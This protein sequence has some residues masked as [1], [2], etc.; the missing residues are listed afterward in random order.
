M[1]TR[2]A[3]GEKRNRKRMAMVATVYSIA[4]HCRCPE[5]IM[6]L[7]EEAQDIPSSR[8]RARNKR[9][10]A[11]VERDPGK[12]TEELFEETHRRDPEH[13]RLWVMLVDGHK[14]QL[15]HIWANI[16]HPAMVRSESTRHCA[17]TLLNFFSTSLNA[18]PLG[19]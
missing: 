14:D 9:V 1:K 10:W 3:Q 4:R 8:L 6:G 19:F 5:A 15:K 2:L 11:S 7:E 18:P 17:M 16:K 12:V 13:R